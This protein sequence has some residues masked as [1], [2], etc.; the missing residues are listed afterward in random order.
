MAE[1]S[2]DLIPQL[3]LSREGHIILAC[4]PSCGGCSREWGAVLWDMLL[5]GPLEGG[6]SPTEQ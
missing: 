6:E 4:L 1:I 2:S 3:L 5:G